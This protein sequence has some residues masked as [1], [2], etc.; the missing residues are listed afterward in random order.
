MPISL[1][2]VKKGVFEKM[3]TQQKKFDCNQYIIAF[4]IILPS[5]VV[6]GFFLQKLDA[7]MAF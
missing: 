1:A 5:L 6:I 7:K 3:L 2:D 4:R